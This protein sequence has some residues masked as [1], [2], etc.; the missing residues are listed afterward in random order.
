MSRS[1]PGVIEEKRGSGPGGK[2]YYYF[3]QAVGSS[4]AVDDRGLN[5]TPG[6]FGLGGRYHTQSYH[7]ASLLRSPGNQCIWDGVIIQ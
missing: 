3:I 4:N 5:G 2:D 6:G 7:P 1:Q